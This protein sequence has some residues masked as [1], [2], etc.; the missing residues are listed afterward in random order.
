M[1]QSCKRRLHKYRYLRTA[2][3][4]RHPRTDAPNGDTKALSIDVFGRDD[5]VRLTALVTDRKLLRRFLLDAG[6]RGLFFRRLSYFATNLTHAPPGP[7]G[8]CR[9]R[10]KRRHLQRIQ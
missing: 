4:A 6:G 7:S 10:Y 3:V 1:T 2:I 8:Q 5:S 9:R